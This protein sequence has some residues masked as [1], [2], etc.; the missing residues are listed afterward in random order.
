MFLRKAMWLVPA[1][2]ALTGLLTASVSACDARYVA[3]TTYELRCVYETVWVTAYDA[4]GCAY[5]VKK[6]VARTVK[7]PVTKL[8]RAY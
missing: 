1:M 7:V 4:D 8:V 6:L 2:V 5:R 3:V